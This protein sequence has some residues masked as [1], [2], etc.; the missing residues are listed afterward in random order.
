ML[1]IFFGLIASFPYF[2][3]I[4]TLLLLPFQFNINPWQFFFFQAFGQIC[5]LIPFYHR[6]RN[7]YSN[8]LETYKDEKLEKQINNGQFQLKNNYENKK[9]NTSINNMFIFIVL[10]I[11]FQFMMIE[12]FF[13]IPTKRKI[14]ETNNEIYFETI[15]PELPIYSTIRRA[16][17][18]IILFIL[19]FIILYLSK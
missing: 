13:E 2:S 16:I 12:S 5:W 11:L 19:S 15:K 4:A 14:N 7:N 18:K 17:G 9:I 10:G 3:V 6:K 8:H 1:S